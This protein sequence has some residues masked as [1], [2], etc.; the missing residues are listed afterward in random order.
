MFYGKFYRISWH[1]H[2]QCVPGPSPPLKE[3]GDKAICAHTN[4]IHMYSFVVVFHTNIA[5]TRYPSCMDT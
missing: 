5:R 2:I 1:V 3:P 4:G